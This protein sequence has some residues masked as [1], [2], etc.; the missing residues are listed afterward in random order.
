MAYT[1]TTWATAD[2]L[3]ATKLNN[4]E[5]GIETVHEDLVP[6]T[7][8]AMEIHSV[9]PV[10]LFEP[11]SVSDTY[12]SAVSF[13]DG[14]TQAIVCSVRWPWTS[15]FTLALKYAA[16]TSETANFYVTVDWKINGAS[17]GSTTVSL[18]PSGTSLQDYTFATLLAS[19]LTAG[20]LLTMTFTRSGA[21]A[22][23]T[24]TGD[25]NVYHMRFVKV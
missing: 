3:T 15:G 14:F 7:E 21:H 25:L 24:H 2:V 9:T 20:D 6:V 23:D 5:E 13:L 8:R 10:N 1:K 18:S 22:S 12:G 19:G 4:I 16:T 11:E 17:P